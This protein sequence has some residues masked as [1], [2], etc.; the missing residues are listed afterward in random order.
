MNIVASLLSLLVH[1]VHPST[2]EP[3]ADLTPRLYESSPTHPFGEPNP[4]APQELAQFN[5]LIGTYECVDQITDLDGK[6]T[7]LDARWTGK[8]ILN[9][10]GIQDY[11]WNSLYST[12]NVRIYDETLSKWQVSYFRQP[13][14]RS[15]VWIG[16][17]EGPD[18]ILRRTFERDG[19][20]VESRLTFHNITRSGF[21]WTAE[22]IAGDIRYTHWTSTCQRAE[23]VNV[24]QD[25]STP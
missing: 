9:G 4:D 11:Y 10:Y 22:Y 18:L 3:D 12:T 21:K 5:F 25:G 14:Y 24:L 16:G 17:A 13:N 23:G 7:Q 20:S 6:T 15:G 19:Q 2:V 8:Y 1:I